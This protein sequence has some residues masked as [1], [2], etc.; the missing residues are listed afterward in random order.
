MSRRPSLQAPFQPPVVE[1]FSDSRTH[2]PGGPSRHVRIAQA[3]SQGG[4]A[5]SKSEDGLRCVVAG[6]DCALYQQLSSTL[7]NQCVIN[8]VKNIARVGT[9]DAS[10]PRPQ[11]L[12]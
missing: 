12:C 6:K 11:D 3:A 5:I 2:G 4:G 10:L 1:I 8:S 9:W 7:N